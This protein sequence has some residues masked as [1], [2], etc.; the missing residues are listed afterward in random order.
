MKFKE[1]PFMKKVGKWGSLM[2]LALMTAIV[3]S[4]LLVL[5]CPSGCSPD[6][7]SC[8]PR[9]KLSPKPLDR[10]TTLPKVRVWA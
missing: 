6:S 8:G 1:M 9:Q 7:S 10:P 4:V 3:I 2:I 5:C